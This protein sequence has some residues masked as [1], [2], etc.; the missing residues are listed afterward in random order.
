[1]G[2]VIALLVIIILIMLFGREGF[3]GMIGG[4]FYIIGVLL[5]WG[6]LLLAVISIILLLIG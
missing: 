4:T 3:L 2:I 1:M 6:A 5:F